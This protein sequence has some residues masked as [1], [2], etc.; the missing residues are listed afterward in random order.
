L[1]R[2]RRDRSGASLTSAGYPSL[3]L[4]AR[5]YLYVFTRHGGR[6][7]AL[8]RAGGAEGGSRRNRPR[9]GIASS[10]TSNWSVAFGGM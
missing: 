10:S 2:S 4:V 9:Y 1:R 7:P 8:R 6:S 5:I 3:H